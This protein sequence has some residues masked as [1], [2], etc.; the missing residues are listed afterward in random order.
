MSRHRFQFGEQI[1]AGHTH[2]TGKDVDIEICIIQVAFDNIHCSVEHLFIHWIGSQHLCKSLRLLTEFLL[3]QSAGVHE[4]ITTRNQQVCIKW[5]GDIIVRTDLQSFDIV[6]YGR[7]CSQQHNR[8]MASVEIRL[9]PFTKFRTGHTRHDNIAQYNARHLFLY[10]FQ[11]FFSVRSGTDLIERFEDTCQH[12]L[13][14]FIIFHYQ[15]LGAFNPFIFFLFPF[16]IRY[17]LH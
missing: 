1:G 11:S 17:Y 10:H 6:L 12:L 7:A 5:F 2:F 15:H 8:D 16:R 4:V 9:D 3:Q 14:R 13:D